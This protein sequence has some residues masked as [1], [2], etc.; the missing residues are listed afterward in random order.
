VVTEGQLVITT[1]AEVDDL[2]HR[3]RQVAQRLQAC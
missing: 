1:S 2:L 3:H